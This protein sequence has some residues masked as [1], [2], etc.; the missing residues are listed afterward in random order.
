MSTCDYLVDLDFPHDPVSSTYEPRYAVQSD[1]W[2]R[3]ACLPFLDARHSSLLT[4]TLW[5][6]GET[7]QSLNKYGDYCL[8]RH[9][10]NV[11]DKIRVVGEAIAKGKIK[12]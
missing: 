11:E 2:E 1:T 10:Q 7:W 3:V 6:P 8:L 4:R 5:L 9:K 12:L